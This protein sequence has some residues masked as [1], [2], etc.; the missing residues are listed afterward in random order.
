MGQISGLAKCSD[1]AWNNFLLLLTGQNKLP[2][3]KTVG[4]PPPNAI[5]RFDSM[6]DILPTSNNH[7]C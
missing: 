3:S 6:G 5:S 4:G 1:R 2:G 7:V